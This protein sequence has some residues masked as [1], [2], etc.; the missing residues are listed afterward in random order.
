[1]I[2]QPD[3]TQSGQLPN[4]NNNGTASQQHHKGIDALYLEV[5]PL[6]ESTIDDLRPLRSPLL[7]PKE[8]E[9]SIN[10]VLLRMPM[11]QPAYTF[12]HDPWKPEG[13]ARYDKPVELGINATGKLSTLPERHL[14]RNERVYFKSELQAFDQL[15]IEVFQFK[16]ADRQLAYTIKY[17]LFSDFQ[18]LISQTKAH[19]A[20][21]I[22]E[23]DQD[24]LPKI[25]VWGT[26]NRPL[27]YWRPKDF[28]ILGVNFWLQTE[29]LLTALADRIRE[30]N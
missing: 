2:E 14:S 17:A 10:P 20:E 1:M 24:A 4:N 19:I 26:E 18:D 8:L 11:L 9:G 30:R 28:K 16:S 5:N 7:L 22:S 25:P 15:L 29:T 21:K 12:L 3:P 23:F 6:L 27:Q 13:R